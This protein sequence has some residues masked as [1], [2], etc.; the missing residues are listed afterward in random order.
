MDD[1]FNTAQALGAI[2]DLVRCVNRVVTEAPKPQDIVRRLLSRSRKVLEE[3]GM[4]MGIFRTEPRAYLD[5]A[6]ERKLVELGITREEIDILIE[7]RSAAR[8]ARDFSKSDEIR[9]ALL[10]RNIVLLD[11]P[12]GTD[13]KI[14]QL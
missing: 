7:E 9:D 2:F 12:Q 10:A 8:K 6:R 3:A 5:R 14:R 11:S 4:V 13:W 1:D